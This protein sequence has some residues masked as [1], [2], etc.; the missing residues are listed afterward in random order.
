MCNIGKD[1]PFRDEVKVSLGQLAAEP[2]EAVV[3][4][5]YFS[6]GDSV[7]GGADLL[8]VVTDKASFDVAAPC[9]GR[10][11]KIMATIGTKI[12]HSDVVAIICPFQEAG[13][14]RGECR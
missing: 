11:T 10:L 6:E 2:G 12:K 4:S 14:D 13:P 7:P 8:E 5:W 9:A 1:S 3:T